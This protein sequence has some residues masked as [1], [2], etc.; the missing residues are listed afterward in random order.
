RRGLDIESLA[1]TPVP[2]MTQDQVIGQSPNA[3]ASSI[4][5]PK[6]GLLTSAAVPPQA[7][8]MPNFVGQTLGNVTQIVK[9]SGFKL[10]Q[11]TLA[12]PDAESTQPV[13]PSAPTSVIVS[14]NPVAG[15]KI[16][17]GDAISFAVR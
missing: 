9:Q 5:S 12:P 17:L 11:V 10:G 2:G 6:M 13:L 4:S 7:F 15:Q 14:Q 8:V 16:I 1:Q 3:S